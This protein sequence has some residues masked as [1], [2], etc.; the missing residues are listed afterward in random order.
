MQSRI[1]TIAAIALTATF[2]LTACGRSHND[3]SQAG[4]DVAYPSTSAPATTPTMSSPAT[5]DTTT[6]A[7][8][9]KHHSKLKGALLG[10]AAGHVLGGHAVAGAAAGAIIQHER[11]K[12][13]Y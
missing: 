4:G 6:T 8:A 2:P 13:P 3:Q 1:R 10:A 5:V 12:H 7:I 9:P 11:N